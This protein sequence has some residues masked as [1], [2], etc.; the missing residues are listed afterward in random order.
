MQQSQLI[1]CQEIR[2]VYTHWHYFSQQ[3]EWKEIR[4]EGHVK[5]FGQVFRSAQ[6]HKIFEKI[7]N[8]PTW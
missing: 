4:Y 6:P 8:P 2:F 1:H 3:K 5:N 7:W